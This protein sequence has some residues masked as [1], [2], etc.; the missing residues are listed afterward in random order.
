[1]DQ[2]KS[3]PTCKNSPVDLSGT[4]L[5]ETPILEPTLNLESGSLDGTLPSNL[6]NLSYLEYNKSYCHKTSH[7]AN[8][9]LQLEIYC[10]WNH[11]DEISMTEKLTWIDYI[12]QIQFTDWIQTLTLYSL[13]WFST[14]SQSLVS[15]CQQSQLSI[16]SLSDYPLIC[17]IFYFDAIPI[18]SF[19][20]LHFAFQSICVDW[21]IFEQYWDTQFSFRSKADTMNI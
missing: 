21:K 17:F 2:L 7:S 15:S 4:Y 5:G 1:M 8:F 18:H 3:K 13:M 10:E 6:S 20:T 19:K 9:D 16:G 14:S 12:Q 11:W